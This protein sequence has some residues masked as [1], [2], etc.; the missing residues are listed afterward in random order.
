LAAY[1]DTAERY[2]YCIRTNVPVLLNCFNGFRKNIKGW[3]KYLKSEKNPSE[4]LR[5]GNDMAVWAEQNIGY[6]EDC[7]GKT[8]IERCGSL[9]GQ[10]QELTRKVE[11]WS[12][13]D[14]EGELE[15]LQR[16]L[17]ELKGIEKEN[18]FLKEMQG[19]GNKILTI[20]ES[21]ACRSAG[22]TDWFDLD[23]WVLAQ[24]RLDFQVRLDQM[25]TDLVRERFSRR[26]DMVPS[27]IA[28][29]RSH[30]ES[31][32]VETNLKSDLFEELQK[33]VQYLSQ[34][35]NLLAETD[36]GGTCNVTSLAMA[37][38]YLGIPNPRPEMRYPDALE[39]IR[40]EN[41]LLARTHIWPI[42]EHLGV[43]YGDIGFNIQEDRPW[44]EKNVRDAHLRQGHSV[45]LSITGHIVRVESVT[46]KGLVVDDPY[47]KAKL[48][49]GTGR[50]WTQK[51]PRSADQSAG[52]HY[53]GNS[54]IWPWG[55]LK[56]HAV[57][58]IRFLKR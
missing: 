53:P 47:G 31:I 4:E 58:W 26:I 9:H 51:N 3:D 13:H 22:M 8:V 57:K 34:R 27:E 24:E 43:Q 11:H 14:I 1:A 30:I 21:L 16:A 52:S 38:M 10:K 46:E 39:T 19:V 41:N 23:S 35:S 37:L 54:T 5:W 48:H 28:E 12:E 49:P 32:K 25:R 36:E 55:D 45:M 33:Q 29:M 17:R 2:G 50:S 18:A 44:Y 56:Q 20:D 7:V 6:L 42:V 15:S 40:V